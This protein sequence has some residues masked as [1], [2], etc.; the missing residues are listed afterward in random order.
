MPGVQRFKNIPL[1]PMAVAGSRAA[2]RRAIFL[3]RQ[4]VNCSVLA[5]KPHGFAT[6]ITLE[7]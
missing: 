6:P 1:V 2:L 3:A 7:R 5:L 4:D